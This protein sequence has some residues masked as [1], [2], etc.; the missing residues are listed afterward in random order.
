MSTSSA[1]E[2]ANG[3]G[4]LIG[5]LLAPLRLPE[6]ALGALE[7]LSAAAQHLGPI[8]D[9]I[10]RVRELIESTRE[11]VEQVP[12]MLGT[13]RR[14][15]EQA[16]PLE[17]ML[18]AIDRLEKNMSA[19]LDSMNDVLGALESDE[20]HLNRAVENLCGRMETMHETMLAL[21]DDVERVT[22]RMP[23]PDRGPLEKAKD[24]L[25]GSA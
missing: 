12:E 25:T 14:I 20:S 24:V 22:D 16:E 9:E 5:G 3:N 19:R 11:R 2:R 10:V 18:P 8:R 13:V 21:K 4:S 15:S 7:T 23:D 17:E 6:R 1:D